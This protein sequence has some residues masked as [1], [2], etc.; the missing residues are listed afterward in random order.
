MKLNIIVHILVYLDRYLNE[1]YY[2]TMSNAVNILLILNVKMQILQF[3]TISVQTKL[4][5]KDFEFFKSQAPTALIF[6]NLSKRT[7]V[8]FFDMSLLIWWVR[9][10]IL[11]NGCFVYART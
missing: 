8:Y 2:Q 5:T 3:T 4:P 7:K 9:V 6:L 1:I 11:K 10:N